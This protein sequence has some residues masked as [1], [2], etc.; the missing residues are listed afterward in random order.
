MSAPPEHFVTIFD[1]TFSPQ[2]LALH[3]SLRT[4]HPNAILWVICMDEPVLEL[5][6]SLADDSLRPIDVASI[7]TEEL[8]RLRIE[9]SHGEYCWTLTPTAPAAVFD[10]DLTVSRVTYVDADLY[11]LSN[12]SPVLDELET[13]G[14]S[15][16]IT[17]HGFDPAYDRSATNGRYCVQF[18]TFVRDSSDVVR[19]SWEKQCRNW[20]FDRSEDGKFGDQKYLDDW[21]TTFSSY[22]HVYQKL[23]A[24]QAPWNAKRFPASEAVAWHFQGLRLI[25]NGRV[26]MQRGYDIPEAVER[27]IY[28]PYLRELSGFIHRMDL[29]DTQAHMRR[30]DVVVSTAASGLRFVRRRVS[31]HLRSY[32]RLSRL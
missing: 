10:L 11:F 4:H 32:G 30:F 6:S 14:K 18:I 15:V 29:V 28:E 5:I 7:E 9:R 25:G 17:E 20:C 12:P 21:P 27:N 24:F 3:A 19:L 2:G 1:F 23:G 13:S 26:L 8:K 22:V 31:A 16:L